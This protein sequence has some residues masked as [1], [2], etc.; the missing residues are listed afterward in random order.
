MPRTTNQKQALEN[1]AL[2]ASSKSEGMRMLLEADYT[3][4]EVRTVFDAPYGFVYGVAKRG[5]F[6]TPEP[7]AAKPEAK[8]EK[9]P[10]RAAKP[11]AAKTTARRT[12]TAAKA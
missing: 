4:A 10:P 5:G 12:R 2:A 3:V 6:I 7:R 11:A 9:R 8:A 1:K